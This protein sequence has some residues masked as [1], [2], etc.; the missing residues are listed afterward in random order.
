MELLNPEKSICNKEVSHLT[1]AV[2]EYICSPVRVLSSSWIRVLIQRHT[3]E[4]SKAMGV[5]WEMSRYPVK[6][7]ADTVLMHVIHEI[8]E[9]GRCAVSAGR[10]VVI[11]NLIAP[12]A[13]KRILCNTH[14]LYMGI[15]HFLNV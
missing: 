9:I 6:D 8:H 7:N 11:C 2:I 10:C 5:S 4:T 3:V 13:V 14:K 12:G 15:T 1:S